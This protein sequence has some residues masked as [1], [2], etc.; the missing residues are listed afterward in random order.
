MKRRQ[1]SMFDWLFDQLLLP[2]ALSSNPSTSTTSSNLVYFESFLSWWSKKM[3]SL[4]KPTKKKSLD[5]N[6]CKGLGFFNL[7][8]LPFPRYLGGT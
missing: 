1:L 4:R 8:L 6:S 3:S 7:K 5:H 2:M